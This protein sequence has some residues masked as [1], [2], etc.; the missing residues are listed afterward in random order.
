MSNKKRSRKDIESVKKRILEHEVKLQ[1][2]KERKDPLLEAY[3]TKEIGH[4]EDFKGH[5]EHRIIPKKK[6]KKF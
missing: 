1:A 4:L 5:L 3:Y 2:A 6:R